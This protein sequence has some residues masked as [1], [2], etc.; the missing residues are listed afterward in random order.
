MTPF[1]A[2]IGTFDG[3][4]RGHQAVVARA[5]HMAD[6]FGISVAGVTFDPHPKVVVA[7]DRAP[8]LL[9][10]MPEKVEALSAAGCDEVWVLEFNRALASL[11]PEEFLH[12]HLM[13]RG[14][15]R[16]LVVG[17]DFAMGRDRVGSV[18][19]LRRLGE[20]LG[21]P[22]EQVPVLA[23]ATGP[24]SSSR[25]RAAL[26]EG[27]LDEVTQSLGRPYRL[28]GRVM[29]GRGE[30]TKLGFPTANLEVD[31]LQMLPR[32]GVYAVRV[33]GDDLQ[34]EY[35]GALNI[36]IRPTYELN[37]VSIEVH[38]LDFSR[39]LRG[40]GLILEFVAFLRPE[41]KFN[42]VQEL[43]DQIKRDTHRVRKALEGPK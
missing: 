8:K 1:V 13:T 9:T 37:T 36:G 19:H 34:G 4:H 28:R 14:E 12:A 32:H 31:P 23:D 25:I 21:F 41:Q 22:V 27:H 20:K 33:T 5:R 39:D 30:G 38:L 3:V 11:S 35:M 43:A 24:I 26:T 40:Q 15:L 42:G 29:K 6:S 16:G 2:T 7:P 17:H 18:G 10:L